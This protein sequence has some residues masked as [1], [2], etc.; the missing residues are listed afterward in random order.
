MAQINNW[1]DRQIESH[2]EAKNRDG[3]GLPLLLLGSLSVRETLCRRRS[4]CVPGEARL[5]F[6][7]DVEDVQ[8]ELQAGFVVPMTWVAFSSAGVALLLALDFLFF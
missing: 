7:F 1:S 2:F 3:T 4:S 8:A 5:L 6:E